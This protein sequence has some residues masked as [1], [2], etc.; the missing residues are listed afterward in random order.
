MNEKA[1]YYS[2]ISCLKHIFF[3]Y[4]YFILFTYLRIRQYRPIQVLF[5]NTGHCFVNT[6]LIDFFCSAVAGSSEVWEK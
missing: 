2:I 6:G 4:L 1:F 5:A 3:S